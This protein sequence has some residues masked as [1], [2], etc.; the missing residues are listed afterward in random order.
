MLHP[1]VLASAYF[2]NLQDGAWW[3]YMQYEDEATLP[4]LGDF[5]QRQRRASNDGG[6]DM[7]SGRA[8]S[9][10]C[11]GRGAHIFGNLKHGDRTQ[12]L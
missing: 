1:N 4:F 5:A 7:A 2:T 8:S 9:C 6:T 10:S 11:D 3:H 12:V